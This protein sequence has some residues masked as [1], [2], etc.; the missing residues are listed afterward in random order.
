DFIVEY[1][2]QTRGWFYLLHVLST[3]L[4]DRPAFKNVVSHGI[5]LGSDGQKMSKSLRNY[6]NVNE[7][8][9]R[10]GSDAMRWFL[11]SSSVL[12]GGNLIVTEEGIREGTRQMLLPL[13]STWYFFSLYAN[14]SDYTATWRTDSTDV[15]DRYLLA[16]TRDLIEG[17]TADLE[18]LDS[19][20][21]A[22][23]LR[24]F[25]D[26]LT[27]WYVRRSRDRFWGGVAADGTGSDAFDT[28]YTVLETL[29]R[30]AAPLLPLVSER[31][32]QGLT[33][34][35]SVHLTDWP[36]ATAFPADAG[37]VTA[38]DKIRLI[39]STVLSL[40]KKASLRVRLPLANL[41]VVTTDVAA[42]AGFE[43]IL[44]DELNVK[45]VSLVEQ[46]DGSAESYGITSKL[47][48]NARAAGPRLGK[49]VQQVIKAA[50]TGD[51]SETDGIVT[52]GGI[53][54]AAGEYELELQA[55]STA[56]DA[57]SVLNSSALALLAGG[58][59]VLLETTTTPELEAEGLAR[60]LI[61]AVQDTRKSAGFE[62]SDRIRLD[63]VFFDEADAATFALAA[64][65]DVAAETLATRFQT[66]TSSSVDAAVLA[67]GTPAE[68]LPRLT[69]TPVEHYVRFE[70]NHYANSAPVIVAVARDK[71]TINV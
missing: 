26:V 44:R 3:A 31:I 57:D 5:V 24:D 53:E 36:D 17:V 54:L 27:N 46:E 50:R 52:A 33:G 11:M 13:W 39:S 9:D 43:G 70:A 12:R 10:D 29:T 56:A 71:G 2:G 60:D 14:A 64:A 15:L 37:L 49:Q 65:V 47:T 69:G 68:W 34:G 42:L 40:R 59:F 61:R 32:W 1:I 35:R 51:W 55:A 22:S 41:T 4:F 16:K 21:A 45:A 25:A 66:H 28:L 7:V 8:F 38:M 20:V 62:V 30:V 58:G 67:A 19:T 6:P 23:R 48:V 63:L 18:R